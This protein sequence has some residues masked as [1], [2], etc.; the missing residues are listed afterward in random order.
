MMAVHALVHTTGVVFDREYVP[1]EVAYL[2]VTGLAQDFLVKSP[3]SFREAKKR[4]P[5]IRPD[6][7]MSTRDGF[8]LDDIR[9]FLLSR[10]AFLQKLLN[11]PD[12][13]FG[14]KGDSYQ[15]TFLDRM[16]LP[17]VLNVER[18]L[19]PT[20]ARLRYMYPFLIFPECPHHVTSSRCARATVHLLFLYMTQQN[21]ILS[22]GQQ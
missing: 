20:I 5:R 3:L 21:L 14:Y 12:V 22:I 13:V 19:V 1:L 10:N 9:Q 4:F 15:K 7:K 18:F 8:T 11:R 2:D 16:R 17:H 6:A